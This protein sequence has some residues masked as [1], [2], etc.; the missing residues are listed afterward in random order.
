VARFIADQRTFYRVPYAVCCA[1]LGV[2]QSWF[3]KWFNRPTT[4]GQRRRA[5][6]DAEVLRLFIASRRSYGSPRVH[7]DLLEAGWTVGVNTVAD[8][9]RRQ[10]LK[11]RNPSAVRV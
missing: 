7:A 4:V 3:Y 10:G 6:L 11:G 5:E 9:M 8:S 1:I 2:S